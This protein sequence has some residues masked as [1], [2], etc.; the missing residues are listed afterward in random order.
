MEKFKVKTTS[1]GGLRNKVYSSGDVVTQA[2]LADDVSELAAKGFLEP[3]NKKA[4]DSE[5]KEAP[6]QSFISPSVKDEESV[7]YPPMSE[8]T[9]KEIKEALGDEA[10]K[11]KVKKSDLYDMLVNG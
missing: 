2:N 3:L 11:G 8:M 9:V 10:P 7:E 5:P 6:E 4:E 1:L